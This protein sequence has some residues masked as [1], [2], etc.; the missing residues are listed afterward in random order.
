MT[1][2]NI[3]KMPWTALFAALLGVSVAWAFPWSAIQ[4]V[5]DT[6][7]PV[8]I[9]SAN[10]VS[11]TSDSVTLHL[12]GE[13]KRDCKFISVHA[14]TRV[15]PPMRDASI[16]R[17]DKPQDSETRPIGFHDFGTWM[18]WPM[19]GA[20]FAAVYVKYECDGRAV[21]MRSPEIEL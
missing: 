4:E 11:R 9:I 8:S 21:L 17:I 20:S 7:R 3:R 1:I 10:V 15:G 14:F 16:V 18:V 19:D 13:K 5:Y 12:T 2:Y 6:V